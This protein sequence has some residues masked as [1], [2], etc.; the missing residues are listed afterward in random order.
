MMT[1][2]VMQGWT[3]FFAAEAGAAG[4]FAAWVL[5]IEVQC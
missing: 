4:I 1:P 3:D 5:L 2:D